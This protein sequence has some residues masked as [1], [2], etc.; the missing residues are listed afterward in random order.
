[1][2]VYRWKQGSRL[3]GDAQEVGEVCAKLERKG[4]LTPK[5]L[6][7]ASRSEKSPLHGYFE[8]DDEKAAEAYR[9]TQAAYLIRSV[10]IVV[11]GSAEPV[12]AF[13]S[14]TAEGGERSYMDV[15]AA[16]SM[17]ETRDEVLDRA[18]AELRAFERKYNTLSELAGVLEAI[19]K[20]A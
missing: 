1:M 8:W 20:V 18:L 14:V 4:D 19:R 12:R 3:S 10:E 7:D 17:Q 5:A 2:T 9:E 15:Q 6:V 16:L 11:S 13:V